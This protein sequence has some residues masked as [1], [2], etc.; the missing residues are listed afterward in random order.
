[1]LCNAIHSNPDFLQIEQIDRL[2]Q[3][4]GI[5]EISY[6]NYL[7]LLCT[8]AFQLDLKWTKRSTHHTQVVNTNSTSSN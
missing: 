4:Q 6:H 3:A 1:M 5:S 8:M 2:S 7:L